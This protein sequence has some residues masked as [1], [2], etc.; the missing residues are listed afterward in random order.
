MTRTILLGILTLAALAAGLFWSDPVRMML[1]RDSAL[2][3]VENLF[4]S[5]ARAVEVMRSR[6]GFRLKAKINGSSALMLVDTGATTVLL[7]HETAKAAGL[8][9]AM[10]DYN[11]G[12]ETA[13]GDIQVARVT[14]DRL[15]IGHLTQ[16]KVPALIAQRGQIKTNLL[17][18]SFL[19]RLESYEVRADTLKLR[20][21]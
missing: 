19:N 8:P 15:T 1:A 14:L 5:E 13:G 12:V 16:S 17:G 6:D 2:L 18:M 3:F 20:G 7:T 21:H 9:L 10:L 11:V 4:T